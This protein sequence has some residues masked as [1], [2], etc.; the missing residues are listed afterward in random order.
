MVR[1]AG[2]E[3]LA[4][5]QLLVRRAEIVEQISF[6]RRVVAAA[7]HNEHGR[8]FDESKRNMHRFVSIVSMCH[9][10]TCEGVVSISESIYSR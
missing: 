7:A 3:D 8:L 6:R 9:V 10:N 5:A 2:D 4:N 1:S